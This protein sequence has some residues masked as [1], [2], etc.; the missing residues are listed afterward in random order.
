MVYQIVDKVK[1]RPPAFFWARVHE[2]VVTELGAAAYLL[3]EMPTWV[4]DRVFAWRSRPNCFMCF[5]QRRYEWAG[6]FDIHPQLFARAEALE[7]SFAGDRRENAYY[8]IGKDFPLSRIRER[9]SELVQKRVQAVAS[10]IRKKQQ[11]EL[12]T[13]AL[14]DEMEIAQKSCGLYCGK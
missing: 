5:Y 11:R 6:L 14:V 13:D 9:F 3:N 12:W 10:M 8:F 1:L 7:N 4:F 2:A